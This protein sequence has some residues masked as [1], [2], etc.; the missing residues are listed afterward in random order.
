M[1]QTFLKDRMNKY[2]KNHHSDENRILIT[3]EQTKLQLRKNGLDDYLMKNRLAKIKFDLN[4]FAHLKIY[5]EELN[6]ISPDSDREFQIYDQKIEVLKNILFESTNLE[7]IITNEERAK[8]AIMKMRE[9]SCHFESKNDE[10]FEFDHE[11]F[12]I[13]T[14]VLFHNSDPKIHYEIT[15]FLQNLVNESTEYKNIILSE[16][17]ML[18]SL[19][20]IFSFS[21]EEGIIENLTN[22]YD[23]IASGPSEVLILEEILP[24]LKHRLLQLG[25]A[26]SVYE[27]ELD[28][29]I[30]FRTFLIVFQLL[31]R[32]AK[33]TDQNTLISPILPSM[34]KAYGMEAQIAKEIKIS[35]LHSFDNILRELDDF[36]VVDLFLNSPFLNTIIK[37]LDPKNDLDVLKLATRVLA[38]LIANSNESR[39]D[40]ILNYDMINKL[41]FILNEFLITET[42]NK[43]LF[44][45]IC[46]CVSN[47]SAG[48]TNQIEKVLESNFIQII[49]KFI[50][51]YFDP[52]YIYEFL[53]IIC[54]IYES[55][56]DSQR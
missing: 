1:D 3:R 26:F 32:I 40:Q 45:E 46:F 9:M 36:S 25:N 6:S 27:N 51:L 42:Y 2:N 28:F 17:N 39:T 56:N 54:N 5:L 23:I 49:L 11:L 29:Q 15:W 21:K 13:L 52:I 33:A 4:K 48:T 55:G 31:W 22:I 34:I 43:H 14:N 53:F 10:S 44:K 8:Y 20:H 38:N 47:I 24:D 35:I 41:I 50:P 16:P 18:I 37:D 7:G 12:D 30:S 19:Y